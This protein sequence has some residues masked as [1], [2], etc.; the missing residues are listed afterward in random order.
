MAFVL[1]LVI[2]KTSLQSQYILFNKYFAIKLKQN[3]SN[4]SFVKF[5]NAF[6]V[7]LVS[8]GLS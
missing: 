8:N 1:A 3:N 6:I 2:K 7:A 5:S 4:T